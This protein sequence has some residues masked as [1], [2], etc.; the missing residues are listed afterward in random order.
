MR[1]FR[2]RHADYLNPSASSTSKRGNNDDHA[3]NTD[4]I[5]LRIAT[6][7]ELVEAGTNRQEANAA[8]HNNALKEL[9]S[10]FTALQNGADE[11]LSASTHSSNANAEATVEL[12]PLWNTN[13]PQ[14]DP[15]WCKEL[16]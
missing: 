1:K 12:D 10:D 7:R 3:Y 4:E 6:L 14:R 9:S 8:A 2:A 5:N 13:S 16:S 11:H 15:K